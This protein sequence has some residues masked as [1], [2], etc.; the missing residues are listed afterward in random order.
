MK[1]RSFCFGK[2]TRARICLR[3]AAAL[4]A[5]C[6]ITFSV[7]LGGCTTSVGSAALPLSES[8]V[9][10]TKGMSRAGQVMALSDE[11]NTACAEAAADFAIRFMRNCAKDGESSVVSPV[12]L[13][14]ALGMVVNGAEGDTL[15][16]AEDVLGMDRQTYNAFLG[17]YTDYLRRASFTKVSLANSVWFAD[18]MEVKESFL[19]DNVA[20]Y[21]AEAFQA[22]MNELTTDAVN[23]WVRTNT[24]DM[25]PKIYEELPEAV[26]L[27]VN[28]TALQAKWIL[29]FEKSGLKMPFTMRDG[30]EK[31]V[32]MM[33]NTENYFISDQYAQGIIKE[34]YDG[35][36]FAAI[37]P[38]E[39][40]T[41]GQY[42]NQID[43]EQLTRML[44]EYSAEPVEVTMPEFTAETTLDLRTALEEL[45]FDFLLRPDVD[46]SGMTDEKLI[47]VSGGRQKTHIA[48][49]PEGTEA[50]A[51]SAITVTAA[52]ADIPSDNSA[53]RIVFD[54]PFLYVIY[55][56]SNMVP[57]FIG[58]CEEP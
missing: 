39:G 4:L 49:S 57:I 40:M 25:I 45:E 52:A 26:M 33:N 55:N 11:E 30:K 46:L 31:R 3:Q 5:V 43:G 21:D 14:C 9:E 34:Y 27:L 1:R 42:L 48:V 19:R 13:L 10:L 7:I 38:E 12:S 18:K 41:V 8:I 28:A 29:P 15:K 35:F 17:A 54:R 32:E 58:A 56:R 6:S 16:Q 37:L 23:E 36:A 47:Y 20:I 50:A 24:F 53:R 2:R 44:S 22:P 51:A